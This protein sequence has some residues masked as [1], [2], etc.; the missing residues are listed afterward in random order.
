[1]CPRIRSLPQ[2]L[3]S[4][5]SSREFNVVVAQLGDRFDAALLAEA[6][7]TGIPNYAVGYDNI[8]VAA[9]AL[10]TSW[11]VTPPGC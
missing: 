4:A 8:D 11:W 5:C 10:T 6:K 7:I 2:Q 9:G 3:Q 1:M